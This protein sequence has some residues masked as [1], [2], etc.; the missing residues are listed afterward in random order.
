M[1]IS[2]TLEHIQKYFLELVLTTLLVACI[3]IWSAV[4]AQTPSGTLKVAVLNIGQGD[5]IYI[6]G[7][8][9]VQIL[10]DAGPNDGSVLRELP[11]VMPLFDHSLD[12]VVATHPDA[13]HIG[14]FIDVLKRYD[15]GK[16]VEPGIIDTTATY[17]T[18]EQEVIDG[19]IPRYV[20]RRGMVLDL[21]G[22]AQLRVLYPD[23]DVTHYT[24]RTNDG[25]IVAHLVYG[26][27]SV[28]L[29]ADAPIA[30]EDHLMS[31]STTTGPDSLQSGIL[32]VGHHGSQYSTSDAFV[33][34]AHPQVALISVGAKN[35]YGHPT[36]RVLDTLATAHVPVLRTDEVGTIEYESDGETFTRV[37]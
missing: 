20:A 5:S 17:K 22:G 13:D 15:V 36:Q 10:V 4:Y 7:P 26:K 21:G 37:K 8:T 1:S 25:S 14:G 31:I 24:N 35:K 19:N 30:V 2:R 33:A 28:L 27:T 11:K 9:G 18:L 29:T 23:L 3:S 34:A 6:E 16:F 32:K 12:A